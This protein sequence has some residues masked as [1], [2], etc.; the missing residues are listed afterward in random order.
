MKAKPNIAALAALLVAMISVAA[1]ES[2][3]AESIRADQRPV[4][5]VEGDLGLT[6]IPF[7]SCDGLFAI[8]E[9]QEFVRSFVIGGNADP[10]EGEWDVSGGKPED[11][12]GW[13]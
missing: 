1:C 4:I 2:F 8:G 9:A 7:V 6:L 13:N 3:A 12:L 5:G 11:P 10:I